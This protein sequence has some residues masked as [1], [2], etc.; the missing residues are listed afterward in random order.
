MQERSYRGLLHGLAFLAL[1]IDQISKYAVF[2]WVAT[3]PGMRYP[4]IATGDDRGFFLEIRPDRV[5]QGALF[6]FLG[7]FGGSANGGFAIVT[8]VVAIAILWWSFRKGTCTDP[9]F[10]AALGLI[11]GGSIGNLYDRLLF[12]GVRD[13]LHWDHLLGIPWPWVFNLADVCLVA[14]AGLLLIQ[15]FFAQPAATPEHRP[16]PVE[17]MPATTA[18]KM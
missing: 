2:A 12:N 5:N 8:L 9:W 10:C 18:Q 17:A 11:L 15:A 7:E 14:G 3:V 13:F 16:E 1:A 6:G 4:L